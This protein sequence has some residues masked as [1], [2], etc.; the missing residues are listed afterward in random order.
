MFDARP[1]R[2][3][4]SH[5]ISDIKTTHHRSRIFPSPI[6]HGEEAGSYLYLKKKSNKSIE[7]HDD[8]PNTRQTLE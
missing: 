2:R 5:K 1:Y 6:G 4:K 3:V 7:V 8:N